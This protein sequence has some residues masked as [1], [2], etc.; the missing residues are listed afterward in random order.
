MAF[1]FRKNKYTEYSNLALCYALMLL[2]IPV[3]IYGLCYLY[4]PGQPEGICSGIYYLINRHTENI[5]VHDYLMW[6]DRIAGALFFCI[7]YWIIG[8][9]VY[10]KLKEKKKSLKIAIGFEW[11]VSAAAGVVA[12]L[13]YLLFF[14][15]P[16][17]EDYTIG[18]IYLLLGILS[19]QNPATVLLGYFGN[20]LLPHYIVYI[21]LAPVSV[22][23]VLAF[24][25][26]HQKLKS[27]K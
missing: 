6:G 17:A 11:G 9:Y 12:G 22:L 3:I 19:M 8:V 26:L 7:A 20:S 23:L 27:L 18:I 25:K 21:L 15:I 2:K 14:L 10:P 5:E 16:N 13:L 24:S 1:I 4:I